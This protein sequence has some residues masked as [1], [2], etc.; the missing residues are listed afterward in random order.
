MDRKAWLKKRRT[1]IGGS[2]AAAICGLDPWR[3][4][5]DVY[6]TKT[7][8]VDDPPN[9]AMRR[10]TVL[11][12]A[13]RQM[14]SDATGNEI[15]TPDE[16]VTH[17]KHEWMLA[18]LDG[19]V[20]SQIVYEGKTS[21]D[22][23]GWGEPWSPDIPVPYICQTQ[24]YLAVTGREVAHVACLF[25][26]FEFGVYEVPADRE[27][28]EMLIEQEQAFWKRV[29]DRDPPDARTLAD[30]PKRWPISKP[31][32]V[33]ANAEVIDAAVRMLTMKRLIAQAEAV[34]DECEALIKGAMREGEA[35]VCGDEVVATWKSAKGSTRFD[36]KRFESEHQD[37]YKQYLT[38]SAGSRRF[39]LK[40]AKCIENLTTDKLTQVNNLACLAL[41]QD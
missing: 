4:V 6:L 39:L 14:Y 17:P 10:G 38:H 33:E 31:M 24:H 3:T 1:G 34:S 28:Q 2:D 20:E 8:D 13:V 5:L 36:T 11:E 40:G 15:L 9:D 27:F 23:R 12:P 41:A 22:R 26:D 30:M 29:L 19:L 18:S 37:L 25:G 35:I 21:R 16:I 32:T 7:E